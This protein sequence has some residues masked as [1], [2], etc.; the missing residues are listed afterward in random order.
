M[1]IYDYVTVGPNIRFVPDFA[2]GVE[3]VTVA[4]EYSEEGDGEGEGWKAAWDPD[5]GAGYFCIPLRVWEAFQHY[6]RSVHG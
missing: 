1:S 2:G 3:S 6:G 5:I 4:V